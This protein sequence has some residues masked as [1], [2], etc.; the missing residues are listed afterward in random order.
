MHGAGQLRPAANQIVM[1]TN[2]SSFFLAAAMMLA[3]VPSAFAQETTFNVDMTCAPAFDNVFVTGPWCGWCFNDVYNTMT[4]PDGDGVYTVTLDETVTGIIEYKYAIDGFTGQEDLVNDMI[5]GASCAPITDY[6]A[7]ANRQTPQGSTTNDNYGTCDGTCND[8]PLTSVT[9]HVDMSGYEGSYD[10]SQVTWN[11]SANG[12][13]GNCAPMEDPDGD[14]IYSL[15]LQL[16]GD[17]IEYKF[18]IGQW[19]D[20]EDL[21]PESSCTVTTYSDGAPNGCCYVNRVVSVVGEEPIDLPVV[22]WNSCEACGF[23]PTPGCIDVGACNYDAGATEDDGSCDYESCID[24][25]VLFMSRLQ[26]DSM[27]QTAMELGP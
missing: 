24:E 18:A 1:P 20:Q 9:F 7:Y 2:L 3:A 15:T 22:C 23:V 5:E 17:S 11:G 25:S 12:W 21:T 16:E 26:M 6:N 27:D 14:G 4:D 13:C 19:D 8:V 10:P